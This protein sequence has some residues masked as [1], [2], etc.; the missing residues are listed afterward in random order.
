MQNDF[1]NDYDVIS[2]YGVI[3]DYSDKELEQIVKDMER[4]Q[5]FGSGNFP[6]HCPPLRTASGTRF[7]W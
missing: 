3:Y 2:K 1:N 4:K 7:G 5:K 6:A